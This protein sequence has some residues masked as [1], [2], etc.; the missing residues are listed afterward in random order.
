[1]QGEQSG[2]CSN[3]ETSTYSYERFESRFG[4]KG[5][6]TLQGSLQ[7]IPFTNAAKHRDSQGHCR[8]QE[9]FPPTPE[10]GMDGRNTLSNSSGKTILNETI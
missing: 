2:A 7:S 10:A 9:Q 4:S 5:K 1:M 8:S 6:G 3:F